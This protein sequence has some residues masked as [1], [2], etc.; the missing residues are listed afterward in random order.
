MTTGATPGKKHV[1][2]KY[3]SKSVSAN[4]PPTAYQDVNKLT[5]KSF[6]YIR[7]ASWNVMTSQEKV[8]RAYLW[9][10]T[11]INKLNEMG[12]LADI[13]RER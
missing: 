10:K 8:H 12:A 2:T 9:M 6:E 11:V 4:L 1:Q 7:F 13:E 5:W 3:I